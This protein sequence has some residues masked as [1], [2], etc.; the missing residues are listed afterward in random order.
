MAAE[1]VKWC[2]GLPH[3]PEIVRM[4]DILAE[5][6]QRVATAFMEVVEWV[7]SEGYPDDEADPDSD[8]TVVFLS[9]S[10]RDKRTVILSH[11]DEIAHL[12][13]M[14]KALEEVGWMEVLEDGVRFKRAARH[15]TETAKRRALAARRQQKKRSPKS[16]PPVTLGALP[17]KRREE[18]NIKN[19]PLPLFS[20]EELI[21][22]WN[23]LPG[24]RKVREATEERRK[25]LSTRWKEEAFRSGLD[26]ALAK[27]PLKCFSDPEAWQPDIDWFLKAGQVVR[28]LEG[29]FDWTKGESIGTKSNQRSGR[30]RTTDHSGEDRHWK[31]KGIANNRPLLPSEGADS[32]F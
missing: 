1:W 29:K 20:L 7:D 10:G 13:G 6:R 28:I 8:I 4:A 23:A 22:R 25:K 16:T 15:N 17:E 19:N 26:A 11:V 12:L 30:F 9:R 21:G 18:K 24:V 3:K 5:H 31:P 32:A 27:F 14:A 2:K